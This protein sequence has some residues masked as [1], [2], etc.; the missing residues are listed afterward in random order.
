VYSS[1]AG[2]T[3]TKRIGPYEVTERHETEEEQCRVTE[4]DLL[5]VEG[6]AGTVR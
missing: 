5:V 6:D 3:V 2:R 1:R 4:G